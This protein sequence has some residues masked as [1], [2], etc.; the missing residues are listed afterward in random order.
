MASGRQSL[1]FSKPKAAGMEVGLMAL[2]TKKRFVLLEH[3]IGHSSMGIVA[4]HAI[5]LDRSV[6]KNE[7]ALLVPMTLE[8]KIIDS[9]DSLQVFDQR[10]M[11]LVTTAAFHLSFSNGMA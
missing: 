9:F 6:L 5:L 1:G 7:G 3:I 11:M 2:E 8:T 10:S 4:N